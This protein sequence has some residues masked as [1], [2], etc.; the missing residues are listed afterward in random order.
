[1]PELK[2]LDEP[3]VVI[4]DERWEVIHTPGHSDGHLCFYHTTKKYL[5]VGDHV[6]D[7]ITPN[8]SLWPGC[9]LNPLEDYI[10]SLNKIGELDIE[11]AFP[12]HGK[13]LTDV[14][15]RIKELI[16]HH[17]ERIKYMESITRSGKTAFEVAIA[18]FGAKKLSPHQWRFAMAE[19]LAHLEHSVY[20]GNLQKRTE[21]RNVIY[22]GLI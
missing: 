12:A 9:S 10:Q 1:M 3:N 20:K 18:T 21:D 6:L 22:Y 16:L 14:K 13:V 8:I 11:K 2:I 15:T 7:K 17:D 5:L 4:A 19:T